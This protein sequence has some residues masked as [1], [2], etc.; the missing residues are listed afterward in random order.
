MAVQQHWL[1]RS[2]TLIYTAAGALHLHTP[3]A[4]A[5]HLHTLQAA[6][7]H[8]HTLQAAALYLH[9]LQAAALHLYCSSITLTYTA[10]ALH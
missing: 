1:P 4:A 3:H 7:L 9:T 2:M 8:L 5:L 6:A 10:A